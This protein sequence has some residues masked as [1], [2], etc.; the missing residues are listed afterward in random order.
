[1]GLLAATSPSPSGKTW[2]P[3]AVSSSDTIQAT[4]L[5]NNGAM[6]LI[7]NGGEGSDTVAISDAGHSA[8]GNP[9]TPSG[10]AVGAGAS[11]AFF[12]SVRA[13][14]PTT[15]MVTVTHTDI[16]DVTYVLVRLG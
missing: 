13:A 5:G 1:M 2:T 4:D 10:G 7:T 15:G 9:A 8:A 3:E 12:V 6:L 11:K 16:T 14:D